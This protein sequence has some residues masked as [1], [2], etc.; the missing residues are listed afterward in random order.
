M[1]GGCG[2]CRRLAVDSTVRGAGPFRQRNEK[3]LVSWTRTG[4]Q[5]R[6]KEVIGGIK[7][8]TGKAVGDAKLTADGKAEKVE[9]KVQNAIGRIKD[10]LKQ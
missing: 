10:A 8:A 2:P 7:E 9:G 4:S 6:Q 3:R 5:D 1:I